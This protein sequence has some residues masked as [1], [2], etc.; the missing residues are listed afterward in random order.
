MA[1]L[2]WRASDSSFVRV[3]VN[4]ATGAV[5]GTTAWTPTT[6]QLE[7]YA[8]ALAVYTLVTVPATTAVSQ[9]LA[10][11]PG[12][13]PHAVELDSQAGSPKWEVEIVTSSGSAVKVRVAAR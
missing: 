2:Q 9:V 5:I 13:L 10:A 4:A 6:V 8:D 12:A 3:A 1:V 7:K 11:N